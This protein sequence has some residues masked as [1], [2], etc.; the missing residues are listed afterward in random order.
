MRLDKLQLVSN[1]HTAFVIAKF[2]LKN[3]LFFYNHCF[4][5]NQKFL[6]SLK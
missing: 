6:F 1:F 2:D 3:F 4:I 5:S